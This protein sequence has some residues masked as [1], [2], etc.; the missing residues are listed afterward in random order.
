MTL[1]EQLFD[2]YFDLE[3]N[4]AE[5]RDHNE[6]IEELLI[7]RKHNFEEQHNWSPAMTD[8]KQF[9]ISE[10]EKDINDYNLLITNKKKR[11]E[12]IKITID[13]IKDDDKIIAYL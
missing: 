1:T 13:N 6:R 3:D 8:E 11:Q 10:I 12:E 9:I 2:E 4:I 5:L 7:I